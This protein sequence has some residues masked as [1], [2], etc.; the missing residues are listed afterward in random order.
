MINLITQKFGLPYIKLLTQHKSQF[1]TDEYGVKD[2]WFKQIIG[3]WDAD[4]YRIFWSKYGKDYLPE[5]YEC[6]YDIDSNITTIKMEYIEGSKL[7]KDQYDPAF[8]F[9]AYKI[10][11]DCYNYTHWANKLEKVY[12]YND[13]K[14][15]NFLINEN[16]LT[17]IDIDSWN[18]SYKNEIASHN[19]SIYNWDFNYESAIRETRKKE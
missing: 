10:I 6:L 4:S 14:F 1:S 2:Y 3:K 15:D 16:K 11:P 9:V 13:Y 7:T 12:S 8:R 18:W 19:F 17:L 5:C